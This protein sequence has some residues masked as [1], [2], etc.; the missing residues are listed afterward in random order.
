[1]VR[2]G[3][4][5]KA[6]VPLSSAIRL[7][8]HSGG[9]HRLLAQVFMQTGKPRDGI[10]QFLLSAEYD[11]RNPEAFYDLGQACLQQALVVADRILAASKTSPYSRRIFAENFIGAGSWGEAET[12]YKLA[13]QAEP[14]AVDLHLAAAEL[15]LRENKLEEAR[16]EASTATQFA[17]ASTAAHFV[18]AE[19]E[20]ALRDLDSALASLGR[21]QTLNP[22]FLA[23]H[24]PFLDFAA[25]GLWWSD[26]CS[27]IKDQ[28]SQG[29]PD[30]GL[31]FLL[32]A[33]RE[34]LHQET[35][36]S[37]ESQGAQ[38]RVSKSPNVTAE[39]QNP[40]DA[41]LAGLCE[42]CQERVGLDRIRKG[43]QA[44][45]TVGRCFYDVRDYAGAYRQFAAAEAVDPQDPAALYW[46]Q[47]S[48]RQL[49]RTAFARL[50]RLAPDSYLVHLLNAQTLE[51]Q[52]QPESAIWEYK[53][54]IA[55]QG[56]VANPH[57]LLA[58]L[59][60]YWE[61][62]DEALPELEEALRLDPADP[63][64]NYLMGDSLVQKHQAENALPYLHQA[65]ELRPGFLNAE[66]SLGR[67]LSQLGR[68]EE[69]V[70]EL[71]K[72][73]TADADGSIHFQLYR[74][75][76]KLGEEDKAQEA[77]AAFKSIRA[78]RLPDSAMD[79]GISA[80]Q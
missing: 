61:R 1:L 13:L 22:G 25:S 68:N 30:A 41:C 45:L 19:V 46:E 64:A 16:R 59:Y 70:S 35:N 55:R 7:N 36:A 33:C 34:A 74:L 23:T 63:A 57:V 66:A 24:P 32:E 11:P 44:R 77:L 78:H 51:R 9:A 29:Q 54:A 15:Y 2:A 60:W 5:A 75:Y 14:E 10:E 28:V 8:P 56:G 49:A 6:I 52:K 43:A 69:A 38:P 26:A 62:Y 71:M 47:E 27:K 37:V 31:A 12:Q 48:A 18:Q 42:V 17:P 4:P 80:P 40:A 79:S 3:P 67:A 20:F 39:Q 73:A 53:L 65:L 72:V 58:H 76:Q 21:V 50:E